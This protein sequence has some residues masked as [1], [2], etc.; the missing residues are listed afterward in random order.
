MFMRA[1]LA[2]GLTVALPVPV[3]GGWLVTGGV[4]VAGCGASE[5]TFVF[6]LETVVA[7]AVAGAVFSVCS[8]GA[9]FAL[10]E[11]FFSLSPVVEDGA[12]LGAMLFPFSAPESEFAV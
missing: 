11:S 9:V 5:V 3:F 2:E 4:T 8:P 1:A 10:S 6:V 12:V 7:D